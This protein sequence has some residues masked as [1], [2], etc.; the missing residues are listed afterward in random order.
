MLKF[1]VLE[2]LNAEEARQITNPA[3]QLRVVRHVSLS[4]RNILE[5]PLP[6]TGGGP[7]LDLGKAKSPP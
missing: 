2:V 4:Y 6:L 1:E 3:D 5:A 7:W